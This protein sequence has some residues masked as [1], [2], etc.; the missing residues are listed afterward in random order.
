MQ[1]RRS[2]RLPASSAMRGCSGGYGVSMF[3]ID[4]THC[5]ISQIPGLLP[6]LQ[7]LVALERS[8]SP[9]RRLLTIE[10]AQGWSMLFYYPMEHLYYLLAHDV[11]PSSIPLPLPF[12]PHTR[13]P[14]D[15]NPASPTFSPTPKALS[16]N[17]DPN[18]DPPP[19][20]LLNPPKPPTL[21][22]DANKLGLW[23][24]RFWAL[25]VLLQLA[26]LRE[27]R[28]LLKRRAKALSKE[29][30]VSVAGGTLSEER[31]ELGRRWDAWWNELAVNLGYLPLTVHW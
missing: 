10:R 5:L 7:W 22:L 29:K 6:I 14:T 11:I 18:P 28:V 4:S 31:K 8:P 25:Y 13:T 16:F 9:T 21:N 3:A 12:L 19:S 2:T 20:S 30:G 15:Y 23:S 26:H 27:D 24:T 17:P 1:P